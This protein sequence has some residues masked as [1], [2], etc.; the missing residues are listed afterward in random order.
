MDPI[1]G[2][3]PFCAREPL[4]VLDFPVPARGP[5]PASRTEELPLCCHPLHPGIRL[6]IPRVRPRLRTRWRPEANSNRRRGQAAPGAWIFSFHSN[7]VPINLTPEAIFQLAISSL[8]LTSTPDVRPG[9]SP[10][11]RQ[12]TA[13]LE[14]AGTNLQ[15]GKARGGGQVISVPGLNVREGEKQVNEDIGN[16]R[17]VQCMARRKKEDTECGQSTL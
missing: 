7:G 6:Q 12:L 5:P 17:A 9:Q 16:H 10:H 4:G 13:H 14:A 2:K 11:D 15:P 8:P 1:L 3:C